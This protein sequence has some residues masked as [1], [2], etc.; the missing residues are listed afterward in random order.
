MVRATDCFYKERIIDVDLALLVRSQWESL[1]EAS[2]KP[3]FRCVECLG[4]VWPHRAGGKNNPAHFEHRGN[5]SAECSRRHR[6]RRG[7]VPGHVQASFE[8]DDLRAIEGYLRDSR[9]LSR[10][11]NQKLAQERKARDKHTCLACGFTAEVNGR[12]I[13]ECHHRRPLSFDGE[14]LVHIDDLMTLCPTCHRIAHTRLEPLS[15][16]EIKSVLAHNARPITAE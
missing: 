7:G 4:R 13:V 12:R 3:D 2:L 5:S 15:L 11:R 14:R 8:P 16:S 9:L 1:G 6:S 10:G